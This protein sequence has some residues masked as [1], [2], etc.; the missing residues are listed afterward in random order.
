MTDDQ[1]LSNV[2]DRR[3]QTKSEQAGQ[4]TQQS[5]VS[6]PAQPDER[7]TPGRKPLFR[8]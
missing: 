8:K 5:Q 4:Q 6:A 3:E 2:D 1:T 7:A